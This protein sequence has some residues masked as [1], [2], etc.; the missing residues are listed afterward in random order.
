MDTAVAGMRTALGGISDAN[1]THRDAIDSAL[2]ANR[3]VI[4]LLKQLNRNGQ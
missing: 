1:Q 4:E 3:A 2:A